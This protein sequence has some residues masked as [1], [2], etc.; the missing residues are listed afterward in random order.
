MTT[1]KSWL[2]EGGE[3][4]FQRIKRR[5]LEAEKS[6]M[7]VI[8]MAIGQP[9]G[10]ALASARAAAAE[11]IYS[12]EMAVHEY[13]DNGSPGCPDFARRFVEAHLLSS[14]EGEDVDFLPI[15]GI[16]PMLGLIPKAC[17]A[18]D[19]PIKV[20]TM[21]NPGYPTP[22]DQCMD[23]HLPI[24]ELPL[25]MENQFVVDVADIDPDVKLLMLNYP[26]NPTG[27]VMTSEGWRK[28]CAFC[29]ERGIRL[30]NDAAY[31][32]LHYQTGTALAH[33][34]PGFPRL[35]WMEGVS[36][37]KSIA[38]GTGWRVGAMVG[39][40]DFIADLS[41]VKGNTDSGFT[42]PQA[43]GAL[44]AMEHDQAGVAECLRIY[45]FRVNLLVSL[46]EGAGLQLAVLPQAGFF[47][48]SLSPNW[49]FGQETPGGEAFNSVMIE[50]AGVVSVPFGSYIRYSVCADVTT[51]AIE[52]S[53]AFAQAKVSYN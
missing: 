35:S 3:N 50:K 31:L 27:Q 39:S 37:S 45:N 51:M 32:A 7:Q 2:P 46:L 6:G 44:Y 10:P 47:T 11:A 30:F 12:R 9:Q 28:I 24:Q 53:N 4:L 20:A 1:L 49:A 14:L 21:T 22:L 43:V 13:Q 52:I 19:H 17:G 25:N 41:R 33:V 15:P 40:P 16:K 29:E 26:H 36:A 38:N 48:L 42:A 34:A 5:R 8:D 23:L 18:V